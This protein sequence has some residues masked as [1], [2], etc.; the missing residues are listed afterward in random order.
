MQTPV[1]A[2][3]VQ[4]VD[5]PQMLGAEKLFRTCWIGVVRPIADFT[6]AI[7]SNFVVIT[8]FQTNPNLWRGRSFFLSCS[9]EKCNHHIPHESGHRLAKAGS[10]Q[11]VMPQRYRTQRAKIMFPFFTGIYILIYFSIFG[12]LE[13][14][15]S[16]QGISDSDS[17]AFLSNF[18]GL[19]KSQMRRSSSSGNDGRHGTFSNTIHGCVLGGAVPVQLPSRSLYQRWVAGKSPIYKCVSIKTAIYRGF[20]SI[21]P[22][23]RIILFAVVVEFNFCW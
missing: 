21:H 12:G 22:C 9:A 5:E 6:M 16:L 3:S 7:L 13:Y 2:M 14:T 10:Y 1:V 23:R 8:Q 11:Q 17:S 18:E 4:R 20:L 19:S 15:Y